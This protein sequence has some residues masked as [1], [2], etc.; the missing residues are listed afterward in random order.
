MRATSSWLRS[1]GTRAR[2]HRHTVV[3]SLAVANEDLGPLEIDVLYAQ[4]YGFHDPQARAVEKPPDE[5]V[6]AAQPIEHPQD[7]FARE[8][9]RQALR[10]PGA[11]DVFEPRQLDVEHLLV[12]EE[13]RALRLVL[14]RS[15]N[16]PRDRKMGQERFDFGRTG[17]RRVALV[18]EPDEASN[19]VD[20]RL[21]SAEAVVLQPN[22]VPHAGE[23]ARRVG[24]VHGAR[25]AVFLGCTIPLCRTIGSL[26]VD[27]GRNYSSRTTTC[28]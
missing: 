21:L 4:P 13:Q 7:F 18:V 3:E 27:S 16:V 23:Q 8:D 22:L 10:R 12:E 5:G 6:H 28:G 9:H 19:P 11:L 15:G 17:R 25:G 26:I 20:V 24:A 14:R 1:C 2:Q